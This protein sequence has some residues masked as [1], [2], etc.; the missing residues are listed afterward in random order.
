MKLGW[1]R[2]GS[3][4][5]MEWLT[6]AGC[7]RSTFAEHCDWYNDCTASGDYTEHR[8]GCKCSHH[9]VLPDLLLPAIALSACSNW[10]LAFYGRR[11]FHYG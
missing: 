4:I 2:R 7:C 1:G 11:V 6:S 8:S 10:A 5:E 9:L 3:N